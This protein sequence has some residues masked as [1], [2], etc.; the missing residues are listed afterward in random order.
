MIDLRPTVT[1]VTLKLHAKPRASLNKVGGEHG[2]GLKVAVTAPP[3]DGKANK[4][5][6]KLLAKAFGVSKSCVVIISGESSRS[7]R[8]AIDGVSIEQARSIL[9]RLK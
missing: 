4:A 1:G 3:V 8:V 9:E 5:I 6:A 7:K 2:G